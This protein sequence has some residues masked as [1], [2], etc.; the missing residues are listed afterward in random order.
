[1]N[2]YIF[3]CPLFIYLACAE[4]SAPFSPQNFRTPSEQEIATNKGVNDLKVNEY[5]LNIDTTAIP[6]VINK[7]RA[8]KEAFDEFSEK[9]INY[10]PVIRPIASMDNISLHPYFTFS[11][12]L[13]SGSVI[14]HVDSSSE[15][16]V[17]KFESN[18]L[19]IRPKSDFHIANF[20][21]LYK[22]KDEN[23][24]LN[25]L[26]TRYEKEPTK[27]KL[28]LIYSYKNIK[29]RDDVETLAIYALEMGSFPKDKY[30]Y[31][32]ID[33]VVYRIVEDSKNGTIGVGEKRYRIDNN[34]V[35]K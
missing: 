20:T 4:S 13:P 16:A 24:I 25:V 6:G 11:L 19:L 14:S 34:T 32:Y 17:M 8:N 7:H 33:G 35:F 30:S 28:N 10:K 31:V 27:D 3:L 12:L 18:T 1:M 15:M 29:K 2:K 21:I 5:Y 26:A 9:E 22:L 23:K